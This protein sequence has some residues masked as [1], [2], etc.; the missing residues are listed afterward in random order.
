[1]KRQHTVSTAMDDAMRLING[2]RNPL[3]RAST[4]SSVIDKALRESQSL[5][6]LASGQAKGLSSVDKALRFATGMTDPVSK[7]AEGS[8]ATKAMRDAMEARRGPFDSIMSRNDPFAEAVRGIKVFPGVDDSLFAGVKTSLD[9][10]ETASAA[11]RDEIAKGQLRDPLKFA[12]DE[13]RMPSLPPMP[14]NPVLK[15][16]ELLDEMIEGQADQRALIEATAEAQKQETELL[17]KLVEAFMTSQTASD[18][19]ARRS[20][21]QAWIGIAVAILT[22]VVTVI[23][24]AMKII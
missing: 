23:L 11:L 10:Y 13:P 9:K 21:M 15:T 16:N 7:L 18:K 20:H 2:T 5:A 4:A 12:S 22:A 6:D 24:Q 3:D 8:F 17:G 19:A 1:M 14:R